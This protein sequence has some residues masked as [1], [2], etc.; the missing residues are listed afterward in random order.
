MLHIDHLPPP[1]GKSKLTAWENDGQLRS[2]SP[3]KAKEINVHNVS[4]QDK[5]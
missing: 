3:S 4:N 5:Y 2:F 1:P